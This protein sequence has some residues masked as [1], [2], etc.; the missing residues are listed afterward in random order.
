MLQVIDHEPPEVFRT[1]RL[2]L[3]SRQGQVP[4]QNDVPR[5]SHKSE[6]EIVGVPF[7]KSGIVSKAAVLFSVK[8]NR[9]LPSIFQVRRW[10][11]L[12]TVG[13][14]S[15]IPR[16]GGSA[17]LGDVKENKLFLV[18]YDH[19]MSLFVNKFP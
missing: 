5:I 9:I 8:M 18:G 13:D 12:L 19:Q 15:Q 7:T 14:M 2:R 11:L 16:Q 17:R 4:G 6:F 10:R 3:L 1:H